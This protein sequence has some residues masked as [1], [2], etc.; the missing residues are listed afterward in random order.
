MELDTHSINDSSVQSVQRAFQLLRLVAHSDHGCRLGHLVERSGLKKPTAH[1][2]LRQLIADRF[3]VQ[4]PG[5]LYQL[6]PSAFELGI[7]A[8]RAFPL[9]ELAGP[10]L[11]D[12]AET[13]GDAVLLVV[14]SEADSL[15]VDHRQGSFSLKDSEVVP[16]YRRPIGVGAG[17]LAILGFLAPSDQQACLDEVGRKLEARR[18]GN[19][20]V[21]RLYQLAMET[22]ERG[23]ACLPHHA[24]PAITGIAAPLFDRQ[25][26][27][28]GAMTIRASTLR[29]TQPRTSESAALL[30]RAAR[31][32]EQLLA[33]R[34]VQV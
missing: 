32:L 31:R 23:W 34:S 16:G 10:L 4:S 19:L 12:V 30:Q 22:R 29:L 15:C 28:F 11:Q 21:P 8:S 14:K 7:A 26:R 2:L 27:P 18:Y 1:R 20:T 25:G 33:G 9:C 6:G 3:L 5:R 17:G 24:V 13:T